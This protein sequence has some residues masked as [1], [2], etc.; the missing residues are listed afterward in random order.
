MYIY[1]LRYVRRVTYIY[2]YMCVCVLGLVC[3]E[4]TFNIIYKKKLSSLNSAKIVRIHPHTHSYIH[5][6]IP[7]Y[8]HIYMQTYIHIIYTSLIKNH[9]T[10][11]FMFLCFT[12][13]FSLVSLH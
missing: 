6:H 3:K 10:F 13:V 2:I 8:K 4:S 9:G 5:T 12:F 1:I 7:T 11:P